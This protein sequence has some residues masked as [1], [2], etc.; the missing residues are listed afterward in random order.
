MRV[1]QAWR[2]IGRGGRVCVATSTCSR[3]LQ[4]EHLKTKSDR[5]TSCGR[6]AWRLVLCYCRA[7]VSTDGLDTPIGREDKPSQCSGPFTSWA[8]SRSVVVGFSATP[9]ESSTRRRRERARTGPT[10]IIHDIERVKGW[11]L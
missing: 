4:L 8:S 11:A 9:M 3:A 10:L 7:P 2:G 1:A 6:G 5:Y